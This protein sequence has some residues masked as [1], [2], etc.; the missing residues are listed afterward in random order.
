[1]SYNYK[2]A[3]C[4][5][6]NPDIHGYDDNSSKNISSHYLIHTIIDHN[7]F[8]DGSYK[9]IIHHF[10]ISYRNW[11]VNKIINNE[12]ITHPI[13]RNYINV[14]S[15]NSS[16]FYKIHIVNDEI[17]PGQEQVAYIK[18]FWLKIIQRRW[19]TI[20]NERKRILKIRKSFR[21]IRE[22]EMTGHWPKGARIW[23][24]FNLNLKN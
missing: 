3:L 5:P 23:P 6:F 12:I 15:I 18:T 19:R 11:F 1:M 22:R 10:K 8:Y 2:L 20:Y 14:M 9:D 17:L 21:A 7:E 16:N 13:I 24:I 4:S